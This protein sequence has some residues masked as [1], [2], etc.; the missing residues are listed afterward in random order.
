[1]NTCVGIFVDARAQRCIFNYELALKQ[2]ESLIQR[3]DFGN[4]PEYVRSTVEAGLRRSHPFVTVTFWDCDGGLSADGP[5][6]NGEYALL[7]QQETPMYSAL[8]H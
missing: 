3:T 1:M 6:E 2:G 7:I 8:M 5:V 4:D